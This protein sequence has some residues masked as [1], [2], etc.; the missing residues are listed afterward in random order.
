MARK[1]NGILTYIR[2]SVASKSNKVII[3]PYRALM[4]LCLEYCVQCWALQDRKGV[5]T[6]ER[7]QRRETKL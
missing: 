6:L 1:A 5:K 7:V 4:R 3:P 2:N